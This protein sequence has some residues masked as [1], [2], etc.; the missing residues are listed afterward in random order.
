M[1]KSKLYFGKKH[2]H[3]PAEKKR[4]ELY[5]LRGQLMSTLKELQSGQCTIQ[6]V[7]EDNIHLVKMTFQISLEMG[8]I[9]SLRAMNNFYVDLASH[10]TTPVYL[11]FRFRDI[12]DRMDPKDKEAFERWLYPHRHGRLPIRKFGESESHRPFW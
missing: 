4:I 6:V 9:N 2:T 3:S 7:T 12:L 5:N 8:D 10:H 11:R 1:T